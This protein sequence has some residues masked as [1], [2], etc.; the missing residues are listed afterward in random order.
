[1]EMKLQMS[2]EALLREKINIRNPSFLFVLESAIKREKRN[3]YMKEYYQQNKER[4]RL[5]QRGY[6]LKHHVKARKKVQ[7]HKYEQKPERKE[8]MGVYYKKPEAK[9][10]AKEYRQ[11]PE[12]KSK[13][14][15]YHKEYYK[16]NKK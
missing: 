9:A 2:L 14:K 10:R 6:N 13:H 3:E 7:N 8:Y 15:E 1:M 16:R 5:Q 12:V 11:R 4:I